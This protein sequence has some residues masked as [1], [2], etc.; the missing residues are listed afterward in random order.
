MKWFLLRAAI[1]F[2]IAVVFGGLIVL[3]VTCSKAVYVVL[4]AIVLFQL[5]TA[6]DLIARRFWK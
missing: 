1:G 3:M 4:G 2:G 6:S 5:W